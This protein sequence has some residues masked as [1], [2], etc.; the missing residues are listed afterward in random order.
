VVPHEARVDDEPRGDDAEL[1]LVGTAVRPRDLERISKI[2]HRAAGATPFS[3]AE[4]SAD[5]QRQRHDPPPSMRQAG[6][7]TASSMAGSPFCKAEHRPGRDM[8]Q[9]T[10]MLKADGGHD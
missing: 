8:I 6:S 9:K 3:S 7:R 4:R 10:A 1:P 5:P 2:E